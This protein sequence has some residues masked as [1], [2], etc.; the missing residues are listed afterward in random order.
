[1]VL[2]T[3]VYM[4]SYTIT[5]YT[6]YCIP[7]LAIHGILYHSIYGFVHHTH[8]FVHHCALLNVRFRY[9]S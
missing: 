9:T 2:Y 4:V 6:W 7:S 1:M 3:I 5:R 8:G